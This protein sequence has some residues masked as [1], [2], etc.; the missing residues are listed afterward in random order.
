LNSSLCGARIAVIFLQ[1]EITAS[2][3]NVA[4]NVALMRRVMVASVGAS[5]WPD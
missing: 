1:Q 5:K 3:S 2:S 4:G